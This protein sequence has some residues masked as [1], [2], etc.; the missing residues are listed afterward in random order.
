MAATHA[1]AAAWRRERAGDDVTERAVCASGAG[2]V[3]VL[4]ATGAE[5]HGVEVADASGLPREAHWCTTPDGTA[6]VEASQATAH[7]AD[8]AATPL[9]TTSWGVGQLLAAAR[10]SGA[11]RI[12]VGTGGGLV[13][14]A[15]AG[16]LVCLGLRLRVGDGQGLRV[17]GGNVAGLARIERGWAD[18]WQDVDLEVLADTPASLLDAASRLAPR[19][20]E[21]PEEPRGLAAALRRFAAVAA[22]DLPLPGLGPAGHDVAGL[23]D[24]SGAG[25]GGGLAFGLA[26]ALGGTLVDGGSA[27]SDALGLGAAVAAA[28]VVVAVHGVGRPSV[29]PPP[30]AVLSDVAGVDVIDVEGAH[31][32]ASAAEARLDEVAVAAVRSLQGRGGG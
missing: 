16:A 21:D 27:M 23:V 14:D 6:W 22:S 12:R 5:V 15:G 31:L 30:R 4:A 10:A 24:A 1:L 11:D 32:G 25:S 2:L 8:G 3:E 29:V 20:E 18:D 17:G 7:A 19:P 28:D 9:G 26:A 13:A